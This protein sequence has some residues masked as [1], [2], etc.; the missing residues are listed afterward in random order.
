MHNY[1]NITISD[2]MEK[3]QVPSALEM[4]LERCRFILVLNRTVDSIAKKNVL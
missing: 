2:G 1:R 3:A 4:T